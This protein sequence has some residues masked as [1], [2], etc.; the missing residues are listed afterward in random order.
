[1][2]WHKALATSILVSV[3][4]ETHAAKS[5]AVDSNLAKIEKKIRRIDA[6]SEGKLGLLV[7]TI[8]QS[9]E[10]DIEADRQWYL[11]STIKI[12][13]A[14]V[15]LEKVQRGEI[16]LNRE[17]ILRQEDYVDGSGDTNMQ[18]VGA[19]LTV[20]WLFD[21][22]L[23]QSDSAATDLLIRMIGEEELNR[24]LDEIVPGAF[25]RIT[26]ILQVRYDAY[27]E[28][29]PKIKELTNM[30]FFELKKLQND[31]QRL[32]WLVKRMGVKRS[33]LKAKTIKQAFERYYAKG[34]N[35]ATLRGASILLEKLARGQLLSKENTELMLSKMEKIETG[36]DRLA[37][38]LPPGTR[39]AQKTGTQVGRICNLGLVRKPRVEDSVVITA[40]VEKHEEKKNAE[41]VLARVGTEL[42][43]IVR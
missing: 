28:L 4:V 35:S 6:S 26:S 31:E 13:V 29:H 14:I 7:R 37:A 16:P 23:V 30:D 21:R 25:G 24:R 1:M 43:P 3:S 40:C 12:P 10:I 42:A 22:M 18:P 20:D 32:A 33:E 5:A 8:G 39:F 38:G 15:L 41:K 34:L 36:K 9:G 17:I 2:V 27:S 19:K 11:A